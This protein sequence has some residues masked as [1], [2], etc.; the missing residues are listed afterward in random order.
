M[1]WNH[2]VMMFP[3]VFPSGVGKRR[4]TLW[5]RPPDQDSIW[6]EDQKLQVEIN[7]SSEFVPSCYTLSPQK[8]CLRKLKILLLVAVATVIDTASFSSPV[9]LFFRILGW[10][11]WS[12]MEGRSKVVFSLALPHLPLAWYQEFQVFLWSWTTSSST[13]FWQYVHQRIKTSLFSYQPTSILIFPRDSPTTSRTL[14]K[15]QLVKEKKIELHLGP[16]VQGCSCKSAHAHPSIYISILIHIFVTMIFLLALPSSSFSFLLE[17]HWVSTESDC[18][19]ALKEH[20]LKY[21]HG[22]N[23]I[24]IKWQNIYLP[25]LERETKSI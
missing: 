17:H 4:E 2:F 18:S 6:M 25:F 3:R 11:G 1:I 22:N 15:N 19:E 23:Y 21:Q 24:S 14:H 16:K 8:P 7:G 10:C 5:D 9:V 13:P 20:I 12:S